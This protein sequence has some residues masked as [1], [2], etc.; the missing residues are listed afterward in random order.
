MPSIQTTPP[1]AEPVSLADAKAHLRVTHDDDDAYIGTL[2][3]SAR[4]SIEGRTGL[5]LIQQ[6]W[7][8]FL[9]G[10][11]AQAEVRLP[12]A[13]LIDVI[14]IRVWSDADAAAVIDP[15]HYYADNASR[16][17]R[18]VLRGG[19]TWPRPGRMANGIEILL[20]AGFGATAS[21]VPEPLR[22]A[23]LQ[24]VAHWF[25]MRGDEPQ[26]QWPLGVTHLIHPYK[27]YRL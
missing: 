7:S 18:I 10:W 14:D 5:C 26:S 6:G 25:A 2:I 17:P 1:A 11:P 4:V 15:A 8:H 16:S 24:L 9:D 19:R 3:K 27:E 22:Q 12:L 20:S 23:V 13:P 21:S